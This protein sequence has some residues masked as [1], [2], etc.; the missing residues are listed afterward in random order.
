VFNAVAPHPVSNKEL[1]LTL[2]REKKGRF[3]IPVYVPA[4]L[5]RWILG[6]MSVEVLK[7]ATVSCEKIRQSG[8]TFLYPSITAAIRQLAGA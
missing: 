7:S 2:A 8:F 6:E 3:F 4:F 5:L 1:T